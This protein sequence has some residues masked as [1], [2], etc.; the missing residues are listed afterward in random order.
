DGSRPPPREGQAARLRP[1]S[2]ASTLQRRP[3]AEPAA[4]ERSARRARTRRRWRPRRTRPGLESASLGTLPSDVNPRREPCP[5]AHDPATHPGSRGGRQVVSESALCFRPKIRT[6]CDLL[7]YLVHRIRCATTNP[8][9][10]RRPGE[11]PA[12]NPANR[13]NPR[14]TL[15]FRLIPSFSRWGQAGGGGGGRER[16]GAAGDTAGGGTARK[17]G[18]WL[19]PSPRAWASHGVS[20]TVRTRSRP[21]HGPPAPAVIAE[22]LQAHWRNSR[23]RFVTRSAPLLA[24]AHA[25]AR[26]SPNDGMH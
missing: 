8:S 2:P 21:F 22:P 9:K 3:A 16:E 6:R 13:S 24:L 18:L 5:D 23:A 10:I 20:G 25:L 15:R 4:P 7:S 19:R 26:S 11:P 1:P 14:Y 17:R 12:L